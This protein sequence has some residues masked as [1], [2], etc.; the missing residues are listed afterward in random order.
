MSESP[1]LVLV[2][3][4]FSTVDMYNPLVEPLREKGYT[5]HVLQPPCYPAN[6]KAGTTT[7]APGLA[8]DAKFVNDFVEKIANEGN[9]VV[10]LAHS[11][12]GVPASEC[13]KGITAK[14][15]TAQGKKGG[16]VRIAYMTCV[17]P[18]VGENLGTV[19]AAGQGAII[20]IEVGEDG[21]MT[22]A[23]PVATAAIVFNSL[24]PA[25]GAEEAAKF[26]KHSS[27]CFADNLTY[28]GYKDLP[29]S[30]LVCEDDRCVS[31]EVQE[32]G[33]TAIEES[34]KGTER[35]GKKVDVVRLDVDHVPF[36]SKGAEVEKWVV[37]FLEKGG[38]D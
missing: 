27:T 5:I 30:W 2:P 20:P 8:D 7:P 12:G 4:S 17:I 22:N 35:E 13:L 10:L 32:N 24:S 28:A 9:E 16:V 34:W 21:W 6:W 11:Y 37:E 1:V 29:V 15:R 31:P 26:G 18:R 33:I 25:H 23:D 38:K 36:M 14:E 3:G 19:M